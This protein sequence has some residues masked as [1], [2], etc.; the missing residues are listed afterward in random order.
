MR[1]EA[2]AATSSHSSLP[3]PSHDRAHFF[4]RQTVWCTVVLLRR[5]L[6]DARW[7]PGERTLSPEAAEAM[8]ATLATGII[9]EGAAALGATR[10]DSLPQR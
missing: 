5:V 3:H 7:P 2:G 4:G 10:C 6:R 9:G 8:L 1:R